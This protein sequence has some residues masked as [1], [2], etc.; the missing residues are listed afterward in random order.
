MSND[1]LSYGPKSTKPDDVEEAPF[2]VI[3]VSSE[4][5]PYTL[6]RTEG[7]VEVEHHGELEIVLRKDWMTKDRMNKVMNCIGRLGLA[8]IKHK[9][10]PLDKPIGNLYDD[11]PVMLIVTSIGATRI[12]LPDSKGNV[13]RDTIDESMAYQYDLTIPPAQYMDTDE[14]EVKPILETM[15]KGAK[16]D[17]PS[18][19]FPD[20]LIKEFGHDIILQ[21]ILTELFGLT[22]TVKAL[23]DHLLQRGLVKEGELDNKAKE[24]IKS[25]APMFRVIASMIKEKESGKPDND[26]DKN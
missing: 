7:L 15:L 3:S 5:D 23:F 2:H 16:T 17:D 4:D 12:I 25:A 21:A 18:K 8:I 6:L 9:V 10:P 11:G 22:A 24:T 1:Q 26:V 19:N 14:L 13:T 20:A